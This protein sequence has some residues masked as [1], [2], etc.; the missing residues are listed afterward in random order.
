MSP[1]SMVFGTLAG[2]PLPIA[3]PSANPPPPPSGGM[4]PVD[5][6]ET[7]SS[8]RTMVTLAGNQAMWLTHD[9]SGLNTKITDSKL[10]APGCTSRAGRRRVHQIEPDPQDGHTRGEQDES[11]AR[12][13]PR[14]R[15]RSPADGMGGSWLCPN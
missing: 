13:A 9:F 10:D 8:L 6:N 11:A 14:R 3:V 7:A 1:Q 15:G 2:S 5:G 4:Y 12:K